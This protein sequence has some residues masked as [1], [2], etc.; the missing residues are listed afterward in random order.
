MSKNS[1]KDRQSIKHWY[2]AL[3]DVGFLID[4]D[5]MSMLKSDTNSVTFML[6]DT[7]KERVL[8]EHGK[9]EFDNIPYY[10]ILKEH[11]DVLREFKGEWWYEAI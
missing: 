2:R 7:E 11:K 1:K 10:K 3:N 6:Y 4:D 9:Q 5:E 8:R